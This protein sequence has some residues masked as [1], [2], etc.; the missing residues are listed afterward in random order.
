MTEE[1]RRAVVDLPW[2]REQIAPVLPP[3][4][5]DFH[6]HVWCKDQWLVSPGAA[7]VAGAAYMVTDLHYTLEDLAADGARLFPD[8]ACQAV[9]FGNPTPSADR[10][11]TNRYVSGASAWPGRYP[12]LVTGRGLSSRQELEQAIREKGFFGYKVFLNWYGDEYGTV[13]VEDQIGDMEM[14]LADELGLIVL[15]HVP[16]AGRLVDPVVQRGVRAYAGRYP[17]ARLVLAHCGRC[18]LPDEMAKAIGA[19]CDLDN[20]FLDTAM[21]MDPTVLEIV[22]AEIGARRTVFATDLPV[23]AMRGRRVYVQDHW[24]DVVLD[25]YPLSAYRLASNSIRA[26]F[27]AYEIVLAI[28]RAAERTGLSREDTRGIFYENGITL[29]EH[30]LEGKQLHAAKE[31]WGR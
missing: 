28:R 18:Y 13:T 10:V 29:L 26:S 20:V 31:R 27:M 4:V 11:K 3:E 7:D 30:V 17:N 5:L 2:Y 12:L 25:G 8:R 21:V 24:V 19:I 1:E 16:G 23:A 15:L 6:A 14:Q 22:F 9:V